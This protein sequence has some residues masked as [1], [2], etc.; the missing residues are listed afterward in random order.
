MN[1]D[2]LLDAHKGSIIAS[3]ALLCVL[4]LPS[5]AAAQDSTALDIQNFYPIVG[6]GGVFSVEGTPVLRHLGP[7]GSLYLNYASEPLVTKNG[8]DI[9]SI[10]DQQL[11]MHAQAGIGL[12]DVAQLDLSMPLYL[13]SDGRL[14]EDEFSGFAPGDL[15]IRAKGQLLSAE[16]KPVGI[17]LAADL[18]LPTGDDEAFAGA[19]AV[20]G[21]AKLIVDSNIGPVYLAA[22]VG[23]ALR[24]ERELVDMSPGSTL[25]YGLGAEWSLLD[26]LVA[27]GGE[28]YGGT[29]LDDLFGTYRTSPLEGV[30]GAKL[31]TPAGF[32]VVTGAGGGLVP[33]VGSPSFRSFIG[34]VYTHPEKSEP[35]PEPVLDTDEDGLPDDIDKCPQEAEDIDTFADDDGCPD[36]DNDSDQILDADDKCPLEAGVAEKQGCPVLDKDQDGVEDDADKCPEEAGAA[37]NEGCP[38][39]DR[40]EDGVVD[41]EDKCPDI[42]GVAELGGCPRTVL[43]RVKLV[44]TK[45]EILEK[46][47][48]ETGKDTIKPVSFPLLDEVATVLRENP[49]IKKVEVSGHTDSKGK[50]R[51]N[52]K[53]S[54]A[55]ANAVMAYLASK[56]IAAE[57]L[58]A[59]GYGEDKPLVKPEKTDD[60]RAK[61]RRVEFN[62]LEQS[63]KVKEVPVTTPRTIDAPANKPA[64]SVPTEESLGAEEPAPAP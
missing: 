18:R 19:G 12:F 29:Q 24:P 7:S 53:L 25:S 13:V 57:R 41:A 21:G 54:E 30:V 44:G 50:A 26:G 4:A 61:N 51:D 9:E 28:I 23:T 27:L 56:G 63:A 2:A 49:T 43:K 36:P 42:V 1:L 15:A 20:S 35:E 31:H 45:I 47:F 32:S 33:G 17:G 16:E 34:L 6:P 62:I 46:V 5:S 59:V 40:D 22:N 10:V 8:D 48:F 3:V 11:V 39:L 64:L 38:I 14:G 52:Q 37:E 60:D 55:R 58:V